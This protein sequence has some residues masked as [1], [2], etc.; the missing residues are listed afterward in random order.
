MGI[1]FVEQS[2][3][4]KSAKRVGGDKAIRFFI[5]TLKP[6]ISRVHLIGKSLIGRYHPKE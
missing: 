3:I 1:G 2:G 4:R 6:E 5:K